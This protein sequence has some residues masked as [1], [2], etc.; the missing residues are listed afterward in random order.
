M[1]SALM[2]VFYLRNQYAKETY[3]L[4]YSKSFKFY[5]SYLSL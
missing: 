5:F 3:N 2:V 1:V 4:L